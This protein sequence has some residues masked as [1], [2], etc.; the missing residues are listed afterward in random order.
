MKT[1]QQC[2]DFWEHYSMITERAQEKLEVEVQQW[3]EFMR[4]YDRTPKES[5]DYNREGYQLDDRVYSKF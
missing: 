5:H 2:A 1:L 3:L 4:T